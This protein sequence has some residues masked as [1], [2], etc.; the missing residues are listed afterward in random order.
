MPENFKE[1]VEKN[2]VKIE[3]AERRGKLPYFLQDN[4]EYKSILAKYDN[5]NADTDRKAFRKLKNETEKE[6][7]QTLKYN[8]NSKRY[9]THK[10]SVSKNDIAALADHTHNSTEVYAL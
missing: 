9:Y 8:D 5:I 2:G 7:K 3:F 1:W 6:L 4:K 10:I